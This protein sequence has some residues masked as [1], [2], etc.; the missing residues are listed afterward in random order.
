MT[1]E[2]VRAIVLKQSTGKLT[3]TNDHR[4]NLEQALIAPEKISLIARHVKDGRVWDEE[5]HVWLVGQ[6]NRRDGYKIVLRDDGLQFGLASSGFPH[7]RYPVLC[8]WYGGLLSAFL[9]M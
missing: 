2:E 8:G 9:G 4:M 5:I 7:D 3:V 6:E 1:I